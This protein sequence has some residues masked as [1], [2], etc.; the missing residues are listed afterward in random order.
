MR[1]FLLPPFSLIGKNIKGTLMSENEHASNIQ[2]IDKTE[3]G[4]IF[5][6]YFVSVA[7][8]F[9]GLM[10]GIVTGAISGAIP[11]I[12]EEFKLDAIMSGF[13]V[14]I[15]SLACVVGA[16][17]AGYFSDMLGRKK[18]LLISALFF[19]VSSILAALAK[20][21][22]EI[23]IWR[24]ISGFFV[25]I[26]S[27]SSPMYI[28][29]IAPAKIRGFLVS[30]NQ[31]AIVFGMLAAN[32][33]NWLFVDMGPDSWRWMFAFGAIP[34]VIFFISIFF[35]PESPRW[36]SVRGNT[37]E[38]FRILSRVGG[39]TQAQKEIAEIK[40]AIELEKSGSFTELFKPG[41]RML[42]FIGVSLAGLST[43]TGAGPVSYYAPTIFLKAGF[44]SKSVA[45]FVPVIII[46][47]ML[48]CTVV[49]MNIMDRVGRKP[50]LLYG[51]L[52]LT[53]SMI[54]IGLTYHS[55]TIGGKMIV[56]PVIA[57]EGFYTLSVGAISWV[58]IAEIYPNKI[59]GIAMSL[60]AMVLWLG[61]FFT[62]QIFPYMLEKFG[63]GAFYFLAVLCFL[64]FAFTYWKVF[65][66]KGKSLEEIERMWIK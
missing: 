41:L 62:A 27:V 56:L 3:K 53:I 58:Y 59:R 33:V 13:T 5:Y 50:L 40:S 20:S 12:S 48:L 19:V 39:K 51:F 25:G 47:V 36:L 43:L 17:L 18:V 30:F 28:S 60:S 63:Q 4:S 23:I 37:D 15:V 54:M 10:F 52:G 44:E 38:A 21:F 64:G 46:F 1:K 65:E 45:F 24:F 66:T 11:F 16:S 34:A 57:F 26:V 31:F 9:G 35:I 2:S 7:A 32:F 8:A 61:D 6:A 42:F 22:P 55:T 14:A 49:V 29:E